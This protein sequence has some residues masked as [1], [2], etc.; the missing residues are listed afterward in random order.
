MPEFARQS[1]GPVKARGLLVMIF[2]PGLAATP[3]ELSAGTA[4][5]WIVAADF[6][7]NA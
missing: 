7:R 1:V 3:F 6:S 5:T 2:S 4:R